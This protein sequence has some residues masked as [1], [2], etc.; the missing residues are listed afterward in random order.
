[1]RILFTA[2]SL[3]GKKL[4]FEQNSITIG[5]SHTCTL[6]INDAKIS[7][8]HMELSL[9]DD[10]IFLEDLGSHNGVFLNG[11][12]IF[13]ASKVQIGDKI[14]IGKE[15]FC[16]VESLELPKSLEEPKVLD[17][18]PA[19]DLVDGEPTPNDLTD[20]ESTPNDVNELMD[21]EYSANNDPEKKRKESIF[22]ILAL[23]FFCVA[24][25]AIIPA[26]DIDPVLILIDPSE[27][28]KGNVAFVDKIG[29]KE[30][31]KQ[32]Y[33]LNFE[34]EIPGVRIELN[35][36]YKGKVPLEVKGLSPGF[37]NVTCYKKAYHRKDIFINLSSTQNIKIE[38]ERDDAYL[39][40]QTKPEGAKLSF[41][42]DVFGIS[43]SFIRKELLVDKVLNLSLPS[44]SV[45][46][47]KMDELDEE[48]IFDPR[49]CSLR[50]NLPELECEVNV[51]GKF[52]D[53]SNHFIKLDK[54]LPSSYFVSI[55]V[56]GSDLVENHELTLSQGQD[57][58]VES[59]FFTI[60]HYLKL[61]S[62]E[63]FYGML[64]KTNKSNIIFFINED[65]KKDFL[66]RDIESCVPSS[67]AASFGISKGIKVIAKKILPLNENIWIPKVYRGEQGNKEIEVLKTQDVL[68]D[69]K[70]MD[71]LSF[72]NKYADSYIEISGTVSA[73]STD[74]NW[75]TLRL[76]GFVECYFK[77]ESEDL[78]LHGKHVKIK[79]WSMGIRGLDMLVLSECELIQ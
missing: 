31:K 2:G 62:G 70:Q 23:I 5:R 38:L 51:N 48:F 10:V 74:E 18:N 42:D 68:Q 43:P 50:V 3:L 40:F 36:E 69:R 41:K 66:L 71:L 58:V 20:G 54:L 57:L 9:H 65:E 75:H 30:L 4:N 7:G 34:S 12:K 22:I 21:T 26:E 45:I 25:F 76:D 35:G 33:S 49:Y 46:S 27:E 37:Y 61:K 64:K 15:S 60:S 13:Q 55:S 67:K 79:G 77:G 44:Y 28:L 73:I 1:M 16:L 39:D 78:G 6:V 52:I 17:P 32:L 56:K 19:D 72:F 29:P 47:L 24:I 63:E 8:R 11:Q 14:S 59:K 53:S